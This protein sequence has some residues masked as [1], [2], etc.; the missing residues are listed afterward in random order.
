[1]GTIPQRNLR[2]GCGVA[3]AGPAG[4]EGVAGQGGAALRQLCS[5]QVKLKGTEQYI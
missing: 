2:N 5:V 1:M 4:G 3:G